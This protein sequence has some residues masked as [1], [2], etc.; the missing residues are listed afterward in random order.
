MGVSE[1]TVNELVGKV[2][3]A[4]LDEH[5]W[6]IFLEAFARAVGGCSALL[7]S[8]VNLQ[9]HSAA[10]IASV[11]YDPAWQSAYC[12]H[13]VNMDYLTRTW[14]QLEVGEVKSSDQIFNV[15]EE[16]KTELY[17]DYLLPQDKPYVM[18]AFLINDEGKTLLFSAQRSMGAGEFGEDER[19]L[20]G[21]L[22]PHVTR[23][24]QVHRKIGTL[25]AE[26]EYALVAL[27]QLRMGV[28]LTNR[29]GEPLFLNRAAEQLLEPG[30]GINTH[31]GRLILSS[32]SETARLYQLIADAAQGASGTKMGGDMR[33]ALPDGKFLHCQVMPIK[34]EIS[35][36]WD[37]FLTSGRV[38]LFLSKPGGL[39]LPP[40]RLAALYGLT[41]AE[42][43]LAAR[44][45]AFRS[46]E[47]A[48]DDLCITVSTARTQ[49]RTV[50]SK[51]GAKSQ[52]E[53]LMLLATGTLAHCRDE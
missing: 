35:A 52:S 27:D 1:G 16:R 38:A 50:F 34:P 6:T 9:T 19:R 30:Q 41:P 40:K 46:L 47:Q 48:A 8:S 17:N 7:R 10:F 44:L 53:L 13:F 15:A 18:G 4:A 3:D 36:R 39:Q 32:A 42:A 2:Y 24:M 21:L 51:T 14:I 29:C 20:T 5:Q 26:K 25:A 31:Q 12:D 43:R 49:L 45:A 11:G 33:I 37:V 23:A 28:I 22:V